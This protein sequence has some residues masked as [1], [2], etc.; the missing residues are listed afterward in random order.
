MRQLADQMSLVKDALGGGIHRWQS[1]W[2]IS[3]HP[4]QLEA[5][6]A[7]NVFGFRQIPLA[8]QKLTP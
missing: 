2:V 6:Y 1:V 5:L 3:R 8:I 4:Q 7:I